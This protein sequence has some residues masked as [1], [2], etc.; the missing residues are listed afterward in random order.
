MVVWDSATSGSA[1]DGDSTG[2][3]AQR[4]DS[5]AAVVGGEFQVN[6][7][8]SNQQYGQVVAG[9]ADGGLCGG[10]AFLHSGCQRVGHLCPAL[11]CGGRSGRRRIPGE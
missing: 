8:S 7:E 3:F 10:L 5:N 6:T 1:G 4:Y 11:R 9:L 2:V